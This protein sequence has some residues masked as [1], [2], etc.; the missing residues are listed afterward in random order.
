MTSSLPTVSR[1]VAR[2]LDARWL[3]LA[4]GILTFAIAWF[5]AQRLEFNRSIEN[6]FAVD[7]PIVPPYQLLKQTFGGNEIVLVVY[8]DAELLAPDGRGLERLAGVAERLRAVPGVRD[9]LSLDRPIGSTIVD[10]DNLVAQRLRKVFEGYTHSQDGRMA[11][12]VCLLDSDALG[13]SAAGDDRVRTIA[14]LRAIAE[15][16]GQGLKPGMI[17]GEPVMVIEGF[18]SLEVDG[19]LL[20]TWSTSLAALVIFLCFRS[21]RW[22]LIPLAIVQWTLWS[23]YGLLVACDVRLTLVSGM[24][25]A[26]VTVVGIATAVH[27]LVAFRDARAAGLDS[28]AAL[29]ASLQ[30]MAAPVLWSLVTDAAGFGSLMLCQVGPVRDFGLMTTVGALL[31]LPALLLLTPGLALAG[32]WDSTPRRAWGEDRLGAVLGLSSRLVERHAGKLAVVIGA[33]VVAGLIGLRRTQVETD[34]TRNFRPRSSLVRSYETIESRFGGAG[35]IDVLLPAPSQLSWDYVVRVEALESRLRNE[36]RAAGEDGDVRPGLTKVLSAVDALRA[37]TPSDIDALPFA[38]AKDLVIRGGWETMRARMPAFAATL[39]APESEGDDDR[40]WFRIMLRAR[41]RQPAAAKTQVISQV[42]R[43]VA[44]ELSSPEWSR[45]RRGDEPLRGHVTGYFVLLT[46]L[47]SSTVRDQ[48]T[49]FGAATIGVL[50]TL[51]VGLRNWRTALIAIAPNALPI[52]VVL[53]TLGWLDLKLNLG[54]AMIAAV[55]MGLSVDSS[56]HYLM[57]IERRRREGLSYGDALH[58]VQQEVGRPVVFSTLALVVGFAALCGSEFMPTV[59]F[60]MLVSLA[61]CGGLAGNLV[62]LPLLLR[63]FIAEARTREH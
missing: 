48:W 2:L 44:E 56:I 36:V 5:P 11:A 28:R 4:I 17:A 30:R 52:V 10:P 58:A 59:Y 6:M 26:I 54:A 53:G 14:Q 35:V 13:A 7:D 42:E 51:L 20:A 15:S 18:R 40:H 63:L 33:L 62:L 21:L 1:F 9:V 55:S 25:S 47:I 8:E 29:A 19:R 57:A 43:I 45:W 61:M 41:E 23:T 34:F 37:A 31:V 39:Y 60:G 12:A 22:V 38:G 50:I 32:Q 49:S 16:P 3:L 24:L 27:V 46:N